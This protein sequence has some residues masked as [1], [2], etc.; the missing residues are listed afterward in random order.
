MF[1][2]IARVFRTKSVTVMTTRRAQWAAVKAVA[3][4]SGDASLIAS[5]ADAELR[6]RDALA[7]TYGAAA[8]TQ[9]DDRQ[10]DQMYGLALR[11]IEATEEYQANPDVHQELARILYAAA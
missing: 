2:F 3:A 9:L 5:V 4:L 10:T 1:N 7:K 11:L 8:L 6:A